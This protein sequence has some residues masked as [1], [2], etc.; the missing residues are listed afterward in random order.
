VL[1]ATALSST[2]PDATSVTT[3]T[4]SDVPSAAF[5]VKLAAALG[6]LD[7][8]AAATVGSV[9]KYF[10]AGLTGSTVIFQVDRER[11]QRLLMWRMQHLA[12]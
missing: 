10:V 1:A 12:W 4:V 9:I 11:V 2:K 3:G 7:V 5:V 8:T 6:L